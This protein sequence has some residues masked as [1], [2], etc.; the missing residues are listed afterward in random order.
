M[1][2]EDEGWYRRVAV[3]FACFV[4][5]NYIPRNYL[6]LELLVDHEFKCDKKRLAE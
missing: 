5:R 1:I 6:F 3:R 4:N 2:P